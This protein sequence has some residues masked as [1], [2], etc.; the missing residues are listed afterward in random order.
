MGILGGK[1][2]FRLIVLFKDKVYQI[3]DTDIYI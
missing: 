2:G 1:E 3:L